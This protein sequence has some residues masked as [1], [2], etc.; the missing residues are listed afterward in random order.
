LHNLLVQILRKLT[1]FIAFAHTNTQMN[2]GFQLFDKHFINDNIA[3]QRQD[4]RE[5]RGT[6]MAWN[7][8]S[9]NKVTSLYL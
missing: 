5:R 7:S 8:P 1:P 3:L 2:L 4:S 6:T 9:L